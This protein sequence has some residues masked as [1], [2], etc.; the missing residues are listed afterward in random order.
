PKRWLWSHV[1]QPWDAVYAEIR[2]EFDTRTTAGRHIVFDHLLSW[3]VH[4][5]AEHGWRRGGDYLVIDEAGTLVLGAPRE[6]RVSRWA[7]APGKR[8]WSQRELERWS[9]GRRVGLRGDLL[10]WFVPS[11]AGLQVCTV[12]GCPQRVRESSW[13]TTLAHPREHARFRQ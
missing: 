10:F 4:H 11:T 6:R 8:R 13:T 9:A 2:A 1:G 7:L 3:V 5:A 12:D